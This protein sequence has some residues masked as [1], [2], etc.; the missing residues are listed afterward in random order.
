[1]KSL[2]KKAAGLRLERMKSSPLWVGE[3]FQNIHPV[4]PNLRGCPNTP[5]NC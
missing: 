5:R 3:T 2:G 1:M 4:L